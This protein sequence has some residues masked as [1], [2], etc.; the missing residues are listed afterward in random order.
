MKEKV[1]LF[2]VKF[3]IAA[4]LGALCLIGDGYFE[5]MTVFCLVGIFLIIGENYV[6]S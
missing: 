5:A 3:I 2:S 1:K 6:E 4:I